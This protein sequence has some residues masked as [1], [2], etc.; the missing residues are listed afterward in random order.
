MVDRTTVDQPSIDASLIGAA[1]P[2]KKHAACGGGGSITTEKEALQISPY[3]HPRSGNCSLAEKQL[4]LHAE[5][6]D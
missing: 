3:R 4:E 5:T 2:P 6:H 1:S